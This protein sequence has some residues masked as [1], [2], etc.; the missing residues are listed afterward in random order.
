[1]ILRNRLTD[2]MFMNPCIVMSF[3]SFETPARS[4]FGKHYQIQ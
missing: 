2:L 1:M 3:N 4:N